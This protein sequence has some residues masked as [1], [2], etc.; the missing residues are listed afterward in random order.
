MPSSGVDARRCFQDAEIE[1]QLLMHTGRH[2][3]NP[4]NLDAQR[5]FQPLCMNE[6]KR[7]VCS[8][9]LCVRLHPSGRAST[10]PPPRKITS[11]C[12]AGY[13]P[14]ETVVRIWFMLGN[15]DYAILKLRNLA[16]RHKV[17]GGFFPPAGLLRYFHAARYRRK[18]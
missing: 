1:K 5:L 7:S 14:P 13:V 4:A 11:T 18:M 8:Y 3:P 2:L 12:S 15:V 17:A 6:Q 9:Q 16:H 10:L